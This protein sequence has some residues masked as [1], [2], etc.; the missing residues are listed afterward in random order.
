MDQAII[1]A[2]TVGDKTLADAKR[3]AAAAFNNIT[4]SLGPG[5]DKAFNRIFGRFVL[6]VFEAWPVS[7]GFSKSQFDLLHSTRGEALSSSLV[8][9]AYYSK[10]IQERKAGNR[11]KP[12]RPPSDKDR[13]GQR[14]SSA[15][16]RSGGVNLQKVLIF[17]P[18]ERIGE[19]M[20]KAIAQS[21]G[22]FRG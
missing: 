16:P 20:A 22:G 1:K 11:G 9:Y 4:R 15:K 6:E 13:K 14:R 17:D 5:V 3:S 19:M 10:W 7:S 8:N 18:A 21:A 2:S 12:K